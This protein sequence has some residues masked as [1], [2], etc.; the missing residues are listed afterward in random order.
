MLKHN[1]PNPL[2]V[3]QL[4]RVDFLPP[5]FIKVAFS[6][7]AHD[8]S[9]V[10]WI[11]ENFEGRFYYGDYFCETETGA[12]DVQKVAAFEIAGEASYFAL[13]LDTINKYDYTIV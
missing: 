3:H 4:R 8:K 7:S 6:L 13:M 2:S 12:V 9:I 1:E 11:W 10:D 5:H